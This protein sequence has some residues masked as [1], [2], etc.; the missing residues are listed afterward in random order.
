M[1]LNFK[2]SRS[3]LHTMST[4]AGGCHKTGDDLGEEQV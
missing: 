3:K 4:N 2:K 1:F